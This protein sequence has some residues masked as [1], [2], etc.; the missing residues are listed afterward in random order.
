[1]VHLEQR[2]LG[3]MAIFGVLLITPT[4]VMAQ[5]GYA[6]A[7]AEPPPPAETLKFPYACYAQTF[8][9]EW[10][11]YQVN[12]QITVDGNFA[13]SSPQ[14]GC[15]DMSLSVGHQ[16][17]AQIY[18][19]TVGCIL[20]TPYG[21][22]TDALTLP[23]SGPNAANLKISAFIAQNWVN[24]PYDSDRIF[25]GDFRGF[26]PYNVSSRAVTVYDILNPAV[27]TQNEVAPP[28]HATGLT[29]EYDYGTSLDFYPFGRLSWEAKDDW[30]W[31]PP[32][33]T[34]WHDAGASGM[35]CNAIERLGIDGSY[36][37]N[38]VR[39][40]ASVSNPLVAFAPAIDWDV[41]F[42]MRWGERKIRVTAT[43]CRDGFPSY[44]AYVNGRTVF[45]LSDDGNVFS[46]FP[47]CEG[48][49]NA[50]VEIDG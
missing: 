13:N 38:R 16:V 10:Y 8:A 25:G 1:M 5:T 9:P 34:R 37:S 32:K 20:E 48:S 22:F 15:G 47:P 11:C 27:N 40:V 26:E 4:A 12:L 44:E 43:G 36:A 19:Q 17:P 49:V 7:S 39:C 35:Y 24:H 28:Y 31:G 33:K 45:N 23:G 6:Q 50:T 2:V 29:Q 18:D 30:E 3:R 14:W 42:T 41:T 46:L 21:T